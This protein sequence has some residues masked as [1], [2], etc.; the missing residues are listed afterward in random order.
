MKIPK[1]RVPQLA[2]D[3]LKALLEGGDIET[4]TPREV[5]LDLEAVINQYIKDELE[6]SDKARDI[7]AARGL[8][9]TQIGRV[10]RQLADERQFKTDEDGIDYLV[11][12]MIEFLMHSNNVEE[13]F[14]EDHQLRR[15]LRG[16]IR[17]IQADDDKIED[18]VRSRMKHVQEG[19]AI[20]EVEY[21]RILEDVRRRRGL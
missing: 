4:E 11:D 8:P 14:A 12:Q 3:M 5:A 17:A 10:K 13:I 7:V 21:Q 18:T 9:P 1:S 2:Q 20:W 16:P 15:K 19:S 6:I